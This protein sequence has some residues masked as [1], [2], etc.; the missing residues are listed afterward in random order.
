MIS[1]LGE[2]AAVCR[3]ICLLRQRGDAEAA[4]QLEESELPRLRAELGEERL[5]ALLVAEEERVANASALAEILLP[6]LRE[7]HAASAVPPPLTVIHSNTAPIV[8][9]RRPARGTSEPR[10]IADFIDEM[11]AQERAAS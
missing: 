2:C 5:H 11:I 1:P 6:L 4:E 3:R 8:Q 7:T 10:G 9:V